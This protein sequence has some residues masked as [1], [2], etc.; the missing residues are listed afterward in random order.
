ML[1][2]V[3]ASIDRLQS[4]TK[5]FREY[6]TEYIMKVQDDNISREFRRVTNMCSLSPLT[7]SNMIHNEMEGLLK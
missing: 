6:Y 2:T 4:Q 3:K 7:L 1:E 5:P